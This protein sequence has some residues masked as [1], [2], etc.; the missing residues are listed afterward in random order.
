[1]RIRFISSFIDFFCL[2]S[3]KQP[4]W[5]YWGEEKCPGAIYT[6]YLKKVRYHSP[7]KSII[8]GE[9][10]DDISHLEWETVRVR[11]IKAGSLEKLVGSLASEVGE[12]ESTYVNVFLATYRT[13][14]SPKQVLNLLLERYDELRNPNS[15][16]REA[17]RDQNR[18][19]LRQS[20]HV[21]LDQY[22]EDFQ[23]PPNYPCLTQ[24]E[25][26]TSRVMP[27][28]ELDQK[29]HRKGDLIRRS[30]KGG[31]HCSNAAGSTLK[32]SPLINQLLSTSTMPTAPEFNVKSPPS[33]S[34]GK[35]YHHPQYHYTNLIPSRHPS[36][37]NL[38]TTNHGIIPPYSDFLEIPETIFA[39]QLTR[40]DYELFKRVIPHQCLG[41]V[42]SRRDK[43]RDRDCVSVVATVEQ[44]NAVCY[45]VIS[46]I[47]MEP[48]A[49]SSARAKI[50]SKWVDIAQELRVLKNFS[51]LKAIISGLQTNPVYR[52]KKAWSHLPRDKLETF[53]ELAR[54]FSEDNNAL[55]Q[56]ELLV[57]EG[58]ARFADTVGENDHHLQKVLQKHSENSR[59]ISYGTIPYLGTFLTDLT[60]IDTAIPDTTEGLINFDKRRKEFE[61]LAQIKL[62]QGAAKAYHIDG[63]PRFSQWWDSVLVLD[64]REAFEL[65]CQI[66]P[67]LNS[68]ISGGGSAASKDNKYKRKANSLGGFHRKNDSIASTGSSSAS[69][70]LT[71]EHAEQQPSMCQSASSSDILS[72]SDPMPD[73]Q[74][75]RN[76][77]RSKSHSA[78]S[79]ASSNSSLP[80]MDA[81]LASSGNNTTSK[82]EPLGASTP[83]KGSS[84]ST[85]S[86]GDHGSES[87]ATS[88]SMSKTSVASSGSATDSPYRTSEFYIIRV[89]IEEAGPETEGVIMYKS[90]MIGNHEKTKEVIRSAMMKH[91]LEGSPEN[92]TLSQVLPDKELLI[93]EKANVYYAI[94]TQHDLNFTLRE[95]SE[96][97]NTVGGTVSRDSLGLGGEGT[98]RGSRRP[99]RD[100]SK[101]RR[102]LLG[103][104]L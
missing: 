31:P 60:M 86:L 74:Q 55:A 19:T 87:K 90:I 81:S 78:L 38:T 75:S 33:A 12:L 17:M 66:E 63:Q 53:E 61:V 100:N 84:A 98:P 8:N 77:A 32:C 72:Q 67:N 49:K 44:F 99:P 27:D 41:S 85:K 23:E 79:S 102:K 14:A 21:W 9:S 5:R 4:T 95:K 15:P 30:A 47:L 7:S 24:L 54:I 91:G 76:G 29:V 57:R 13:F 103:L 3:F 36:A 26:F 82:S 65:S 52:L 18:K 35:G 70:Q 22:P 37:G 64:E 2:L 88:R 68:G 93:P 1:M 50:I 42:W 10:D 6:V 28:S 69:S 34:N 51:S 104:V 92:Y 80:S 62:L 71:G 45:R 48:E 43:G 40:M 94:S 46:A 89:S 97:L 96:D 56:R 73:H 25:S 39:Q 59:A 11:F 101:A 20:I 16:M 58:T 83:L